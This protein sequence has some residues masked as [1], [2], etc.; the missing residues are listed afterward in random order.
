M[1]HLELRLTPVLTNKPNPIKVDKGVG[2][3]VLNGLTNM[4][5]YDIHF[6]A[7]DASG[8]SSLT[9]STWN[10]PI[11]PTVSVKD[12]DKNVYNIVAIGNQ[13]WMRDNLKSTTYNDSE[14]VFP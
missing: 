8:H 3:L 11:D 5:R 2:S 4:V 9:N 12:A 1:K 10:I 6:Q 7:V 14:E 13:I